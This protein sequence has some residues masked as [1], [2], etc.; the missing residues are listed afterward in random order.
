MAGDQLQFR[1]GTATEHNAFTGALK[2]VTVDTTNKALRLHDGVTPGGIPQARADLANAAAKAPVVPVG[3][4]EA[5][6]GAS[7]PAG[8]LLCYGQNVSRTA[9]AALFAVIGTTFGAGDGSTTFTLPDL[10][11]RTIIGKD[12]MGGAAASR[13]TAAISGI[14][15]ATLGAGGGDQRMQIHAHAYSGIF[16]TGGN[17]QTNIQT[18][19]QWWVNNGLSTADQGAGGSQN[20]QPSL[21][22]NHIIYAGA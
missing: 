11:G 12:D 8:W 3:V 9:Y 18:G 14:A 22:L 21:V 17:T 7:A 1:G 4:V 20:M 6:A 2:E 5:F 13:V 15:G 16:V 10:R 19:G